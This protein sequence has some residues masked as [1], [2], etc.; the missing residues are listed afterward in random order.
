MVLGREGPGA[1]AN[2]TN[3]TP[4]RMVL[5]FFVCSA[6]SAAYV[7]GDRRGGGARGVSNAPPAASCLLLPA[8]R[9]NLISD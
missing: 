6:R 5:M 2:G 9:Y 3:Q 4:G 1:K 7:A 8:F